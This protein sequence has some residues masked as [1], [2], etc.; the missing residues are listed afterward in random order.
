MHVQSEKELLA[1]VFAFHNFSS[2]YISQVKSDHKTSEMAMK[3]LL[4]AAPPQLYHMLL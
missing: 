1:V 4:A 2:A 3:E